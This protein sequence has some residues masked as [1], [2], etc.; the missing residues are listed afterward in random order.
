MSA[1][2]YRPEIDGLRAVAI[3]PVVVFHFFPS[4]FPNGFLG[5]DVF[6][7]ISGYLITG[8]L[9]RSLDNGTFSLTEFWGRRIRRLFPVMA[10]I[11]ITTM[12]AG[13]FTLFGDEWES[14]ALQ[15]TTTLL[16]S[17]N[18]LFWRKAGDYWGQSAESMPLL[19]MWSLAVEEQFYLIFPLT[20]WISVR[21]LGLARTRVAMLSVAIG[22]FLLM[23]VMS[24]THKAAAFY[25]LPTR[26][27]ELLAGCLLSTSVHNNPASISKTGS[28]RRMLLGLIL[29]SAAFYT[30]IDQPGISMPH[31][32]IAVLG[33]CLTLHASA[34]APDNTRWYLAWP[35]LAF[36]GKA[37]YSWYMWHWPIRVMAPRFIFLPTLLILG[38]SF[39]AGL[40]SWALVE[41]TTRF[42][43]TRKLIP[44]TCALLATSI[45][46][47]S[48]PYTTNRPALK[49]QI[50]KKQYESNIQ[51]PYIAEVNGNTGNYK[52]GITV[53]TL[54]APAEKHALLLGDSHGVM[55]YSVLLNICISKDITLTSFAADGGTWPFFIAHGTKPDR[56]YAADMTVDGW[57]PERRVEF[58]IVR[59]EFL[60]AYCPGAIILCGRW[61]HYYNVLGKDQFA[62]YVRDLIHRLPQRSRF[63]ILG[64]P[65]TLPFG[66]SG[67]TSGNLSVPPARAF[68]EEVWER[69]SRYLA[70][71]T[72]KTICSQGNRGHF[73]SVDSVFET[74]TGIRFI[75]EGMILYRDDD[76]LNDAG[77]A[78]CRDLI[79]P[80][81]LEALQMQKTSN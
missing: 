80:S 60:Q 68:A 23:L 27:W 78:R 7:V 43:P 46:S 9:L 66:S 63:L 56:Y 76:H 37:S 79:A 69:Q 18:M 62:A 5:V 28:A 65:P 48:L 54:P 14:L 55:Y 47:I 49:Y 70:H 17:A 4:H 44:L 11:I 33:T 41:K 24:K 67:F 3:I 71:Q 1:H 77:A 22:S 32:A 12:T 38:G 39:I 81:L 21:K 73:V 6:F 72:L 45:L 40:L 36:V 61:S 42:L 8:I 20:L 58:D 50:P 51:P 15:A 16:S 29:V 31:I 59:Q 25:L 52:T 75:D 30:P 34:T 35:P 64:Q 13:Y 2:N 19:H 74:S 26:A 57:N 53:G 10:A